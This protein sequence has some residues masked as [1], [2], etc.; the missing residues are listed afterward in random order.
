MLQTVKCA[1]CSACCIFCS[2]YCAVYAILLVVC[3]VHCMLYT[4][5]CVLCSVCCIFFSVYCAVYAVHLVVCTVHC[6]LYTLYCALSRECTEQ[7]LTRY[8]SLIIVHCKVHC[9][10]YVVPLQENFYNLV[11]YFIF[12]LMILFFMPYLF[13]LSKYFILKGK[14]FLIFFSSILWL[15]TLYL[16]VT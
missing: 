16:Y 11:L 1:L 7:I 14:K 2:V 5:K 13:H 9:T 6:M 12:K 15:Y 3:T 10:M 8:I 4:W